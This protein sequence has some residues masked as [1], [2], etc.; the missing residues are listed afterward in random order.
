MK[1]M[2][3][4]SHFIMTGYVQIKV[5]MFIKYEVYQYKGAMEMQKTSCIMTGCVIMT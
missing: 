1:E 5:V 4:M 2:R 3:V